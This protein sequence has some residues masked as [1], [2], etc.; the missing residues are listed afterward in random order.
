M[1]ASFFI[2]VEAKWSPRRKKL[3]AGSNTL[4][5]IRPFAFSIPKL[6]LLQ[7]MAHAFQ[8]T[9]MES[10]S[11]RGEIEMLEDTIIMKERKFYYSDASDLVCGEDDEDK[12]DES[13]AWWKLESDSDVSTL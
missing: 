7:T 9:I 6:K 5:N 3:K 4:M 1:L 12:L 13:R 10:S 8:G 2:L 11:K